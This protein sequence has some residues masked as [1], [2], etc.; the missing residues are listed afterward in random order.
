MEI[1]VNR[2]PSSR[3]DCQ[4]G[5]LGI[6]S[7]ADVFTHA[8]AYYLSIRYLMAWSSMIQYQSD[9]KQLADML[10]MYK[11]YISEAAPN[12]QC[13]VDLLISSIAATMYTFV[14]CKDCKWTEIIRTYQKSRK[15]YCR[16]C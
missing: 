15:Y 6:L 9:D 2:F 16:C 11:S 7:R 10:K 8:I 14:V 4:I 3:Q 5:F 1:L 13:V 12:N